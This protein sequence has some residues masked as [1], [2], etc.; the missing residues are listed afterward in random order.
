[1]N[2]PKKLKRGQRR[3][4][5]RREGGRERERE[6]GERERKRERE[7][8]SLVQNMSR[9]EVNASHTPILTN[10]TRRKDG[11]RRKASWMQILCVL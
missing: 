1:M 8:I 3:G 4:S 9:H 6:N 11:L 7:T 10:D 2:P 5:E